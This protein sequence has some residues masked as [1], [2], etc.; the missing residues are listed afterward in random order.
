MSTVTRMTVSVPNDLLKYTDRLA[1]EMKISR[2]KLVTDCLIQLEERRKA[3]LLEEGYRTLAKDLR[4][5]AELG[6]E[7]AHEVITKWD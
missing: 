7:V 4:E 5:S 1:R 2:S 6:W 3:S